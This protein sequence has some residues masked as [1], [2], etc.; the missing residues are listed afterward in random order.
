MP[1]V[2]PW[3]YALD[4]ELAGQYYNTV[5]LAYILWK[6]KPPMHTYSQTHQLSDTRLIINA[7]SVM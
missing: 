5:F 6:C 2:I 1:P 3:G 4:A 7:A